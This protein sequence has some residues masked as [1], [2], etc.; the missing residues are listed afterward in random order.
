M[1]K[2]I[3]LTLISSLLLVTCMLPLLCSCS[4]GDTTDKQIPVRIMSYNLL[5]NGING[6]KY[7]DRRK[8]VA[9]IVLDQMPDSFGVQ[10]AHDQWL[11][12]LDELLGEYYAYVGIGRESDGHGETNAIFY[13]KDKYD[14]LDTQTK[15]LSATPDVSGSRFDSEEYIR[16]ATYAVLQ[17]KTSDFVYVH[18]NTHLGLNEDSRIQQ[19]EVLLNVIKHYSEVYPTFVTGDFNDLT[20]SD[21]VSGMVQNGFYNSRLQAKETDD[22]WTYPT[23]INNVDIPDNHKSIID[24]CFNNGHGVNVEQYKVITDIS[25]DGGWS[26]D[27]YPISVDFKVN[28][29]NKSIDSLPSQ[30]RAIEPSDCFNPQRGNSLIAVKLPV[31]AT[32]QNGAKIAIP[33]S[34]C[35]VHM[36]RGLALTDT[37]TVSASLKDNEEISFTKEIS[38][39][40]PTK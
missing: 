29:H 30:I 40:A 36:P 27:H 26:S 11:T 31:I 37:I 25:E 34:L 22:H 7:G 38:V 39:I 16:I 21:A 1:K 18:I 20:D 4:D 24:Y 28:A 8:R 15:W 6:N 33:T 5:V 14:L 2:S 19:I 32:L 10:E 35:D 3:L 23:P 12:A 9:D 17:S 13:R